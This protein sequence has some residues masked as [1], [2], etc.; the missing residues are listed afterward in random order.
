M[1]NFHWP[2]SVVYS[3]FIEIILFQQIKIYSLI[4]FFMGIVNSLI[5]TIF[6]FTLVVI[7]G[8]VMSW[9]SSKS[10]QHRPSNNGHNVV[11]FTGTCKLCITDWPPI[12]ATCPSTEVTY[13]PSLSKWTTATSSAVST[14][15]RGW[16][17]GP[18]SS[19]LRTNDEFRPSHLCWETESIR[20]L[21]T[22]DGT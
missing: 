13:S 10:V 1:F 7:W 20:D 8:V 11:M 5:T 18:R 12:T 3:I 19:F 15:G 14:T 16:S 9:V 2:M 6:N 4:S 21:P 22:F 17:Q